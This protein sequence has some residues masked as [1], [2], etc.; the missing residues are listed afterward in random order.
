MSCHQASRTFRF[1]STPIGPVVPEALQAAVDFARL[2]EKPAPRAQ[3]NQLIHFH[4]GNV[5]RKRGFRKLAVQVPLP[6]GEG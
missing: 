6:P 5:L 1:S 3:G 2:K 4:D